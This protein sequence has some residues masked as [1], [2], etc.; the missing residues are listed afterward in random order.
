[1]TP[2]PTEEWSAV[3][4]GTTPVGP[5]C[6]RCRCLLWSRRNSGRMCAGVDRTP[7]LVLRENHHTAI[8]EKYRLVFIF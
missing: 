6:R 3:L 5:A 1:M 8:K 4:L 7:E 2:G